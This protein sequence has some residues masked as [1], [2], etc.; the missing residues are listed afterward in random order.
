MPTV[1]TLRDGRSIET[2]EDPRKLAERFDASRR[3]GTLIKV[4]ADGEPMW[5]NPHA[6][7]SIHH[8]EP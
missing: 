1:M 4:D 7:V 2:A 8:Y 6:L 5:V 3:D